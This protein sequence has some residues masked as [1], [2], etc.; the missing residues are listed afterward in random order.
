MLLGELAAGPEP[1]AAGLSLIVV[2]G[3][4]AEA[5][6]DRDRAFLGVV[7]GKVSVPQDVFP[8]SSDSDEFAPNGSGVG[9]RTDDSRQSQH[10]Q[11]TV[12]PVLGSRAYE[13]GFDDYERRLDGKLSRAP[14]QTLAERHCVIGRYT[15][16]KALE[17]LRGQD[18]DLAR[19][20]ASNPCPTGRDVERDDVA[21]ESHADLNAR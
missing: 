16:P 11:R 10:P 14:A 7:A 8:P 6:T 15:L 12:L 13:G 2:L 20:A 9:G 19:P 18:R 1:D 3:R 17:F 21:I 5:P 4:H